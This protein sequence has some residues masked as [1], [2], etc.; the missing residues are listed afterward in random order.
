MAWLAAKGVA[1]ESKKLII[2]P[3][4]SSQTHWVGVPHGT[5]AI[6]RQIFTKSSSCNK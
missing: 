4:N 3:Y 1:E 2:K 5:V 6:G